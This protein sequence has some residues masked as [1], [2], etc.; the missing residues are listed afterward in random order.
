MNGVVMEKWIEKDGVIS[1]APFTSDGTTGP[2]WIACL[3]E[4]GVHLL[5]SA[6]K[7]LTPSAMN[8]EL[9]NFKSTKN[10]TYSLFIVK[11]ALYSDHKM[12]SH[13]YDGSKIIPRD[14]VDHDIYSGKFTG[15]KCPQ[16]TLH[17]HSQ[18]IMCWIR[19]LYSD[20]DF[21]KMGLCR[22]R[23]SSSNVMIGDLS[24]GHATLTTGPDEFNPNSM[25]SQGS[26][27]KYLRC[28]GGLLIGSYKNA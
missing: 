6:R 4:R 23:P 17:D 13:E 1:L 10:V 14:I 28:D 7:I 22:I 25:F 8:G 26:Y 16:Q 11:G 24:P 18:E 3:E 9:Y 12:I 19:L 5:C 20:E 15:G 2:E 27:W 21:K